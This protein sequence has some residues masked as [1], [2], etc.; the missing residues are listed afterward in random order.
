VQRKAEIRNIF[1]NYNKKVMAYKST[2][3]EYLN[4][5][6]VANETA[7][8]YSPLILLP[9][10]VIAGLGLSK[11]QLR[12]TKRKMLWQALKTEVKSLFSS[13]EKNS[14]TLGKIGVIIL[15]AIGGIAVFYGLVYFTSLGTAIFLTLLTG[16]LLYLLSRVK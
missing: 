8:D 5:N 16:G 11:K 15:L 6:T 2:T 4:N 14:N 3:I 12:K 9:L 7:N 10:L 13:K 1:R